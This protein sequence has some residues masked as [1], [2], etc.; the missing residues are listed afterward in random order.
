M[1]KIKRQEGAFFDQLTVSILTGNRKIFASDRKFPSP[2]LSV[3]PV[4]YLQMVCPCIF[5]R[6]Q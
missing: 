4:P 2:A 6:R 1:K 3:L 5:G